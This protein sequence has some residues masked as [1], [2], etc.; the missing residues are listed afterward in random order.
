MSYNKAHRKNGINN[1]SGII[2][3]AANFLTLFVLRLSVLHLK[4]ED[5]KGFCQSLD[6]CMQVLFIHVLNRTA[7]CRHPIRLKK[8]AL[9]IIFITPLFI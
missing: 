2:F 5:G 1:Y 3:P 7:E 9:P 6:G 4:L 8:D